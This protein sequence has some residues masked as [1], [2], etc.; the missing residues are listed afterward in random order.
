[1]RCRCEAMGGYYNDMLCCVDETDYMIL[2]ERVQTRSLSYQ[3]A[4]DTLLQH[5]CVIDP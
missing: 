2:I 4:D 5:M 1:M 3:R